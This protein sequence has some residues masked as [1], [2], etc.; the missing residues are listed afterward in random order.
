MSKPISFRVGDEVTVI[1]IAEP[2]MYYRSHTAKGIYKCKFKLLYIRKYEYDFIYYAVKLEVITDY[3]NGKIFP[4]GEIFF[5]RA[6]RIRKFRP[7]AYIEKL[8]DDAKRKKL[9]QMRH[10]SL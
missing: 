10:I 4:K 2:S 6:C 9:F 3:T 1:Q 7:S 5:I 8:K